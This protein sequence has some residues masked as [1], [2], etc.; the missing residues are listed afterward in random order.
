MANDV[1]NIGCKIEIR[2]ENRENGGALFRF[3]LKKEDMGDDE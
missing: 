1:I 3:A 2:A